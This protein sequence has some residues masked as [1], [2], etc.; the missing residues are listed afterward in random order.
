MA[1]GADSAADAIALEK[2]SIRARVLAARDAL[3][4]DRRAAANVAIT[5]RLL[6]HPRYRDARCVAAFSSFGSEFDT[7]A[8]IAD[9]LS[10]GRRL[11][12]PRVDAASR[13]LVFHQVA[14]PA[15]DLRPGVWGIAE[16]DPAKCLAV[17]PAVVDLMLVPGVA[18]ST[19]CARLGYGG[20]FYDRVIPGLPQRAYRLSAAFSIQI[21][22][23]L[24][25]GPHDR[26]VDEVLTEASAYTAASR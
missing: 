15:S 9:V 19:Q 17:D 25:T 14:D 16:P 4:A 6:A 18:F 26:A 1:A 13:T 2:R 7:A 10:T 5:R 22:P 24:P 11:L 8:F 20:G 12:L 23:R 3:S 21:E